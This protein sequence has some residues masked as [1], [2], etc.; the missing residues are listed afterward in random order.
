MSGIKVVT[1]AKKFLGVPY[2]FGGASPS[3][4]DSEGL[5]KYCYK[6]AIGVDLPK[7]TNGLLLGGTKIS[8]ANLKVGDLVFTSSSHVGIYVGDNKII[9]APKVG[10]VVRISEITSFYTARRYV[11]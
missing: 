2:I 3:E 5:V 7:Y 4:F 11:D 8:Q 9:H 10:D 1:F 6:K